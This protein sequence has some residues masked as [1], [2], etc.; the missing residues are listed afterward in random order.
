M[1]NQKK[2]SAEIQ[3]ALLKAGIS[4]CSN[5]SASYIS[6]KNWKNNGFN[7]FSFLAREN[8]NYDKT[9]KRLDAHFRINGELSYLKFLDSTLVKN[10]D[11][12]DMNLELIGTK[13]KRLNNSFTFNFYSQFISDD[14]IYYNDL[15]EPMERWC[16]GFGNPM[17]LDLC[18]GSS[19]KLWKNSRI[20]F[21]Y[22]SL[23]SRVEPRL[24]NTLPTD[25]KVILLEHA[26]IYSEYGFTLQSFI[27]HKFAERLRW[28]NNSRLFFNG[29]APEDL[30]I[31]LRNR[32]IIRLFKH[33][34]LIIDTKM[35]YL[36]VSPYKM[37]FRNEL[38]LSFTVERV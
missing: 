17:S 29:I 6:Y 28:E 38:M 9:G 2:R 15:G 14:E 13:N 8:L 10:N 1:G 25:K 7:S 11:L 37:Q 16:G 31:D 27:R 3:A 26:F 21:N 19:L 24:D 30:D 23:R 20:N 18:Y 22:V 32:V 34:D 36:P 33:L 5:T 12:L 35:R 4:Y